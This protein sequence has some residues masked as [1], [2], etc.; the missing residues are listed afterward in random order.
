MPPYPT[1]PPRVTGAPMCVFAVLSIPSSCVRFL[2]VYVGLSPGACPWFF[3]VLQVFEPLSAPLDPDIW[4]A[5]CVSAWSWP[6]CRP[7]GSISPTW[8]DYSRPN[9]QLSFCQSPA[10]PSNL[11]HPSSSLPLESITRYAYTLTKDSKLLIYVR[12]PLTKDTPK[13]LF[14]R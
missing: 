11:L 14:S 4:P 7:R 2:T 10:L 9:A 8:T 5:S 6:G 13:C 3:S 1:R 12:V